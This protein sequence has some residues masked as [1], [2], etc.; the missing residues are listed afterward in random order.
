MAESDIIVIDYLTENDLDRV[1]AIEAD[2]F[3]TPWTRKDFADAI[4][5]DY[6]LYI[7]ARKD[8]TCIGYCGGVISMPD[9]DITNI[10]VDKNCRGFGIG[11]RLLKEFARILS[12]RS[13]DNLHL[14]VRI[15][16]IP[17]I[18]LYEKNGF[19][20][21]GIRKNFYSKPTEDAMLMTKILGETI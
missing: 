2:S 8:G 1:T 19:A 15:S 6:Y 11:D 10:A 9:A 13:V 16:N 18:S 4:D 12:E 17:A 7:V 14:E 20:K 5:S 21:D 3:S